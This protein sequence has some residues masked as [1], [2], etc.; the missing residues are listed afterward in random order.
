[1]TYCN[2]HLI[3]RNTIIILVLIIFYKGYVNIAG[4]MKDMI[5]RGGENISPREIEELL[6]THPGVSDVSVIGVPDAKY[7]EAVMAWIRPKEDVSIFIAC[8]YK[9]KCLTT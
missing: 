9:Y 8:I 4:R 2:M 1:M 7:G 5:I 6:Y 3:W